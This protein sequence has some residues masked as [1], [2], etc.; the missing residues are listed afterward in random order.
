MA[1]D[2]CACRQFESLEGASVPAYISAYLDSINDLTVIHQRYRCRM[3]GQAWERRSP[4][5]ESD[6][7]RASLVRLGEIQKK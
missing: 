5:N 4:N 6:N 3:C 1:E 7:K 2:H